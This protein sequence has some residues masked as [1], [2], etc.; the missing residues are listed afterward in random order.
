MEAIVVAVRIHIYL[1]AQDFV[2]LK[3][4]ITINPWCILY[5]QPFKYLL[6]SVIQPS[7]FCSD[8][9]WKKNQTNLF[10]MFAYFTILLA[11][12]ALLIKSIFFF[13]TSH[14]NINFRWRIWHFSAFAGFDNFGNLQFISKLKSPMCNLFGNVVQ[15]IRIWYK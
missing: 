3:V 12:K 4:S 14:F 6:A 11:T 10:K 7:L 9:F 15:K 8:E 2:I 13:A 5:F 1:F